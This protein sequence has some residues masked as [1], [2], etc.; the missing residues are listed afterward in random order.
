MLYNIDYTTKNISFLSFYIK[1]IMNTRDYFKLK[2][3]TDRDLIF[4][5]ITNCSINKKHFIEN[6]NNTENNNILCDTFIK[7]TKIIIKPNEKKQIYRYPLYVEFNNKLTKV[8]LVMPYS[9]L[10]FTIIE[11]TTKMARYIL[12]MRMITLHPFMYS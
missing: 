10:T 2:N 4:Y 1:D 3:K 7:Y 12:G 9:K 5:Q 11:D 8:N 6:V